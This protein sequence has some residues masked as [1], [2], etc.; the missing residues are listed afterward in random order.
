[1][2]AFKT[3]LSSVGS[4]LAGGFYVCGALM[5]A[6]FVVCFIGMVYCVLFLIYVSSASFR[7]FRK[8]Y[9]Q[10]TSSQVT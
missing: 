1:M 8:K 6:F 7:F 2:K 5:M 3:S 9:R 10:F 4:K